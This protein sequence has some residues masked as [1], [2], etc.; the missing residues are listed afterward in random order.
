MVNI[1][2]YQ[3]HGIPLQHFDTRTGE[4]LDV[5]ETFQNTLAEY[6]FGETNWK[7]GVVYDRHTTPGELKR[8]ERWKLQLTNGEDRFY[9]ADRSVR[10][11][12]FP[13]NSDGKS[14]GSLCFSETQKFVELQNVRVLVIDHE[15][16]ENRI[17]LDREQAKRLVGDCWCR[18]DKNVHPLVGGEPRTPFQFRLGIKAQANSPV[19]RIAKGTFCPTDLSQ[20]GRGYDMIL[21][22]SAFKGRK[23]TQFEQI[24]PGEYLLDVGVGLFQEAYYGK[25]ALGVQFLNLFPNGTRNDILPRLEKELTKLQKI[26]SDPYQIAQDF[27]EF[28]KNY[29]QK[30]L[31][32]KL[33]LDIP[34]M[35]EDDLK[36]L[37]DLANE[38]TKETVYQLLANDL[39]NHRQLLEHPLVVGILNQHLQGKYRD[40]AT[41]RFVNFESALLQPC[42][43]LKENEFCDSRFPDGQEVIVG[44][45]PI[46]HSNC[47]LVLT[48]R[49]LKD[50]ELMEIK[51]SVWMHPQTAEKIQGDFDGDR[52]FYD[53]AEKYP[54]IRAE[55]LFKQQ[56]ENRY[57]EVV[58][59]S[60]VPHTGDF[61]EIALTNMQNAVG[62]VA[63]NLMK[64]IALE[65]EIDFLPESEKNAYL[66]SISQHYQKIFSNDVKEFLQPWQE[67][68]K[69]FANPDKD[70]RSNDEKLA[71]V[72]ELL[73]DLVG[74]LAQELQVAV[75]SLKSND[76][77]NAEILK[78][79]KYLTNYRPM[80]WLDNYKL[81]NLY[82][83]SILTSNNYSP[84]DTLVRPVNE[85]W[86][87]N[88]L[89][90]RISH[91]F[92]NLFADVRV[93]Q[94][95]L[96]WGQ[97]VVNRY[98]KL[99]NIVYAFKHQYQEAPGPYLEL[100]EPNQ[101]Q[102]L[103]V[104]HCLD[105]T[106]PQ[107]YSL[108]RMQIR[109]KENATKKHRE[110]KYIVFAEVPEQF[111]KNGFPAYKQIGFL[112][113]ALT[114]ENRKFL[115][116]LVEKPATFA[117]KVYPGVTP[118]QV[119]AAS[120]QRHEFAA[121]VVVSISQA[122]QEAQQAKAAAVYQIC[123]RRNADNK[124]YNKGHAA[125]VIFGD[126]I[127]ERLGKLQF[128]QAKAIAVSTPANQYGLPSPNESLPIYIGLEDTPNHPYYGRRAVVIDSKVFGYLEFQKPQ[129]PIGMTARG[130][131][132]PD[133]QTTMQ[134]T[135]SDGSTLKI[136][137]LEK[138]PHA[139]SE[140]QG[141]KATLEIDFVTTNNWK[142]KALAIIYQ[143]QILGEIRDKQTIAILDERDLARRGTRLEATLTRETSDIYTLEVDPDSVTYSNHFLTEKFL[144]PR[145]RVEPENHPTIWA[146]EDYEWEVAP[147]Q[148]IEKPTIRL[149]VDY[150]KTK[151][152]TNYFEQNKIPFTQATDYYDVGREYELGYAVVRLDRAALSNQI[153]QMLHDK[154]GEPLDA[155][156]EGTYYQKL[157][158]ISVS[159]VPET[160]VGN[161]SQFLVSE[162]LARQISNEAIPTAE[163]IKITGK[164]VAMNF[165]L[166]L[167]GEPSSVPVST[168]I[169]AMRG[170]GR[171]HTTRGF[172]PYKAYDL[173]QGD[174]AI[175]TSKDK[176]VL[177]QVGRQYQITPEMVQDSAYRKQW[178]TREKH[179]IKELD[180][181]SKKY[182]NKLWGLETFPIGDYRE[183]KVYD[184]HSQ[185]E[186]L[187]S[188]NASITSGQPLAI[189]ENN[190]KPQTIAPPI[191]IASDSKGLGGAL[192]NPTVLAHNKGNLQNHYPV[193]YQDNPHREATRNK[194]E[195]YNWDKPDGVP[196]ASAEDA[197]QF[198]KNSVPLQEREKLMADI[199]R[200][201]LTQY[202]ELTLTIQQK[203]GIRWLE[204]CSHRTKAKDPYW[205]GGGQDS[206]FVRSL[207]V[208]YQAAIAN[209]E[210]LYAKPDNPYLLVPYAHDNPKLE[211]NH[212]KDRAMAANA[213]Q[214]IGMP[215][216][217]EK[218]SSTADYLKCWNRYNLANTGNYTDR[219][220]VM[221]SGNGPWRASSEQI[222]AVFE[223]HY[224]P[225]LDKAIA[226]KVQFLLGSAPGCDRLVQSYLQERGYQFSQ[227]D[228]GYL[229]GSLKI[230]KQPMESK[231]VDKTTNNFSPSKQDLLT[232]LDEF[233]SP[234]FDPQTLKIQQERTQKVAP[235]LIALLKAKQLSCPDS[236]SY[237]P[238]AQA[239]S[240]EGQQGIIV[241][242]AQ[243][244]RLSLIDKKSNFSKMVAA[245][246][247]LDNG[248]N[249]VVW[250]AHHLPSGSPGLS[251]DDVEKFTDLKFVEII[252][253]TIARYNVEQLSPSSRLT[254]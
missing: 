216:N 247:P 220:L 65:Q 46:P 237:D 182:G 187:P 86:S 245:P 226:S 53:L 223:T 205:E 74:T 98:N 151:D 206:A 156:L 147:N 11:E 218:F 42:L 157:D 31:L 104:I 193:S 162:A 78:A 81:K 192:T 111:D 160:S 236:I 161:K 43:D 242:D 214:F 217:Q 172:E 60:K 143:G 188:A 228:R 87:D 207:T 168:T 33:E 175:A 39:D 58:K 117:V 15:S 215:V 57:A 113:P 1:K 95:D 169:D 227:S 178:A 167:H 108:E 85:V 59:R 94:P 219:D 240:Y 122:P 96:N 49:H 135:L 45:S 253:Q 180:V 204:T 134:A 202:P 110:C 13:N 61:E 21:A 158:E 198:Y 38:D 138:Y 118:S 26:T 4:D 121:S 159:L 139:K 92:Q 173:V 221:V 100:I 70:K 55:V 128:K 165:P 35:S 30:R 116:S 14:Y 171:D 64:V 99:N 153:Y 109:L 136:G 163:T 125:F 183:G 77:P 184:F 66:N 80:S 234:E 140:F 155:H 149:A 83:D 62:L 244:K 28:K 97:Q 19:A 174:L 246:Q 189:D 91:Q 82:L 106:H 48:N 23:G 103:K 197:Y 76:Y 210:N 36:A 22:T 119:K 196:F 34:S 224:K 177:F 241:W 148:F 16:G 2:P 222:Q 232:Q 68:L 250:E 17:E 142:S 5:T 120:R 102:N 24:V 194:A 84:I 37:D 90:P 238:E 225:L 32:K 201:K 9:F 115:D 88:F 229:Q 51:G 145:S 248:K 254:R 243:E 154:F 211:A 27:L 56:P 124:F 71:D 252:K 41:G 101:S 191:N 209:K 18:I 12:V 131:I 190:S 231:I 152:L 150:R 164:P 105:S 170:Y 114:L 200:A 137:T 6:L 179:N 126:Y 3:S 69:A 129:F 166:H 251:Q 230:L 40:L 130:T 176:Q 233:L 141:T 195:I 107:I 203:G 235:I 132:T 79:C 249:E 29:Y 133:L 10:S 144:L 239:Y 54:H 93:T 208:A 47:V 20:I 127:N 186:I 146:T 44:R 89:E 181:L 123:H 72:K 50:K 67:R 212:R 25:Q 213:T 52:P 63:N 75:D 8:F 185:Q 73:H 112:H 199:L 7:V